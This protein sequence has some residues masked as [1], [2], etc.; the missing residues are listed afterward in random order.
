MKRINYYYDVKREMADLCELRYNNN[1]GLF[2]EEKGR[3]YRERDSYLFNYIYD[4]FGYRVGVI[5]SYMD[6]EKNLPKIGWSLMAE[7]TLCKSNIEIEGPYDIPTF[8]DMVD[9]NYMNSKIYP[10]YSFL[11]GL[12][13]FKMDS[14]GTVKK[15]GTIAILSHKQRDML[16]DIALARAIT[17]TPEV[18]K[19]YYCPSAT[20]PT[21]V[22]GLI[23][24]NIFED[25]DRFTTDL[26]E[27]HLY[28][29][30]GID[31]EDCMT[32]D[33]QKYMCKVIR[34]AVRAMEYR[35][36]RYYKYEESK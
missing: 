23:R 4:R 15:L 14:F 16:I 22:K 31:G 33:A 3:A 10:Y 27:N 20:T 17:Y 21:S 30:G 9:A 35:A 8:R 25:D 11:R 13:D 12:M 19:N 28:I 2:E 5:V 32:P 6:K 24:F 1:C 7:L 18:S 26:R 29:A 34:D 36:W